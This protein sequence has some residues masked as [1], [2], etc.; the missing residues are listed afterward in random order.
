MIA[1]SQKRRRLGVEAERT[2][3]LI[4][5]IF[6][7][8]LRDTSTGPGRD[9][10]LM[11]PLGTGSVLEYLVTR[12]AEVCPGEV[13][14]V[15]P[16]SAGA[17]Y[18]G[19]LQASGS[20][21]VRVVRPEGLDGLRNSW[22]LSDYLLIIDPRLWP[23]AGHDFG[24]LADRGRRYR[25]A[26]HAIAVGADP[27]GLRERVECDG[28]GRI[29]RVERLFN[30]MS[31]PDTTA[32]TF[33]SIVPSWALVETMLSSL[34]DVRAA[35]AGAGVCAQDIP[36]PSGVCHLAE[37]AGFLALSE[38]VAR[39]AVREPAPAGFA[40]RAPGVLAG[41][42]TRI[43]PSARLVAPIILQH[44]VAVEEGATIIG[45]AVIGVEARI[46]RQSV[47]AQS[48]VARGSVV[49]RQSCISR[50]VVSGRRA[51]SGAGEDHAG[52]GSWM[53]GV[54]ADES[55]GD[56]DSVAAS[57][58]RVG[59]R[60]RL[61]LAAKRVMD[62]TLA[63][64]GLVVLSPLLLVVAAMIKAT[65]PGPVFFSHRRESQGG[66]EFPC[67]KFRTMV[68]DAHR[69][70]RALYRRNEVDGPQFKLADDP[71]VTRLGR[72]LRATN[73]DELPQLINVLLG[74]MSLVG[75]RPSPFRENQICVP[76][77]R[78]RLSVRPGITGLWQLC[79]DRRCD[80]D[81]HQWI[82]YD[83][84]YVRNLSVRLDVKIILY[85]ILSAAGRRRVPLSRF[86]RPAPGDSQDDRV[87][88][89][90]ERG[91]GAAN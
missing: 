22:E 27:Q 30:V 32:C 58:S 5:L 84:A 14:V 55:L 18:E 42:R 46:G 38:R 8:E 12:L 3:N 66:K 37:A 1:V 82:Y 15:P 9:S 65:S 4:P 51:T 79:R 73:I 80:G 50:R 43:H 85:T 26:T 25:G 17:D 78:A 70:Q 90:T 33:C 63:S 40:L 41:P 64:L 72:W 86:V 36:F 89:C 16:G 24:K 91:A 67:L 60:R 83:L 76:W 6:D 75:P 2:V 28:Q 44:D 48:V 13:L 62:V 47:V 57:P 69:Q 21:A 10:L 11:L 39:Q 68:A 23:A 49:A 7:G 19:R 34:N 77:R 54:T 88:A 29:R 52:A 81:F 59:R 31:W 56:E 74:H 20:C 53:G 35:V 45:P 71:R 61:H 87:A